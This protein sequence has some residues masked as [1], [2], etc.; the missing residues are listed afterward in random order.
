[1]SA[2]DSRSSD[3]RKAYGEVTTKRLYESF[4][5]NNY[6]DC[7]AKKKFEQS[8]G[9][10]KALSEETE[11]ERMHLMTMVE[12]AELSIDLSKKHVPKKFFDKVAYWS[13]KI[14]WIPI[15]LFFKERYGCCAMVLE[16][17]AGVP[18]IV[19]VSK[20]IMSRGPVLTHQHQLDLRR[21]I[22]EKEIF[23]GVIAIR[24]DKATGID[25]YNAL[26]Y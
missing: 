18:G 24:D 1:M 4:K 12:L 6:P 22:T 14:L 16:T 3:K 8:G 20:E 19:G 2:S 21:A 17:V 11:N 25:G 5:E 23:E 7:D 9:W 10:I 26:F 13:V 15:D